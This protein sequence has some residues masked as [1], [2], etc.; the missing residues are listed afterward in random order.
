MRYLVEVGASRKTVVVE[1]RGALHEITVDGRRHTVDVRRIEAHGLS[2]LFA[3]DGDGRPVRQVE[4]AVLTG[5]AAH[6]RDVHV[7]GHVV[8]VTLREGTAA[9]AS[10]AGARSGGSGLQRVLAPMPGKV[11]RVLVAPGETVAARQGLVVV[12]A[13]KMENELKASRAGRVR[14]VSVAPGQLVEAGTVLLTV[15]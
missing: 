11:T 1:R 14:D 10:A 6:S 4:A 9:G 8:S 13:M 15:E 12:E 2:L 5:R 7:R 3:A